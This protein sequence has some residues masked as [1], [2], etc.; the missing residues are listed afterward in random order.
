MKAFLLRY[1]LLLITCAGSFLQASF[2]QSSPSVTSKTKN[3]N[4]ANKTVMENQSF[5][6][7]LLV[8]QTPEAVFN[9]VT[10]PRGWWSEE[11]AG[12][13]AKLN[14]E[15][16][17]HFQDIH[18]S[19]M[20]LT[21]VVPNKKVVW[22]VMDN[23][24]NFTKDKSEWTGNKIVFEITQKDNK[25]QLQFTHQGLVPAYECYDACSNGWTHYIGKS[26]LD[27]I[28]TGKGQ[29]NGIDK[30]ATDD[31]KQR[32]STEEKQPIKM[33]QQDY[34]TSITV[35]ATAHE[36]YKSINNVTAW[37][38]PDLKGSTQQLN[39]E[40]TVQFEDIHLSTQKLIEL[41]PNKKIVWLV[42]NSNLS[43]VEDK[44]EWTNTRIVFDIIPK[45]NK[46]EIRFTHIGLVPEFLCY[47]DCSKGW[48]YFINGSLYKLLTEGKGTP[49]L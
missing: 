39:D 10:N 46:T 36:V 42:T 22:L 40:F 7:T 20:K 27:L 15:F 12:G 23:Q 16:N 34:T 33:K 2:G 26:L 35:D 41:V 44:Q 49:G 1:L 32:L 17:Y 24:F 11:I 13:T 47:K 43:F 30:P 28:T 8:D 25:T 37:W 5:T 4:N 38:T 19:K 21:E 6:T 18:L 9:A 31:E 29:P 48:D 3:V 14:D 45:N